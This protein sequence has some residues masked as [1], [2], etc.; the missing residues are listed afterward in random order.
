[1]DLYETLDPSDTVFPFNWKQSDKIGSF[2]RTQH[3][4]FTEV[5]LKKHKVKQLQL[6]SGLL[7]TKF[8]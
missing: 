2:L 3:S 1:M 4:G 8:I 7:Q 6:S 5:T